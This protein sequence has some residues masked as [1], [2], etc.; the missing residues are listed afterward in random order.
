MQNKTLQNK[1]LDTPIVINADN[2]TNASVIW[3]HGLG[4]D[5]TDFISIIALLD[6]ADVRFILPHAPYQK[7]TLNQGATM[8]AWY[9]LFGLSP[10]SLQDEIGIQA[11]EAYLHQLIAQEIARGIPSHRI[12]LA[13]FSQGGAIALHTALRYPQPLAGV[14]ALS[15]YLPLKQR[16]ATEKSAANQSSPIF[17]AHGRQDTVITLSTSQLSHKALLAEA[18]R[19]DWH[20]YTMA[21]SVCLEEINDIRDFLLAVF[22]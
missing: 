11:S 21:H 22:A 9:D 1:T 5:G 18:Y 20:E 16:L 10:D 7:I 17:M 12:L 19:V 13:G 14:L 4:A 15:T 2:N 6:L 8:R 3:L